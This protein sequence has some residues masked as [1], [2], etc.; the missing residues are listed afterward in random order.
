MAI[1]RSTA[2]GGMPLPV[3]VNC[4]WI[5]VNTLGS[6]GARSVVSLTLQPRTSWRPRFKISTTS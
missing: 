1:A 6:T 5:F 3:T 4:M 2:A